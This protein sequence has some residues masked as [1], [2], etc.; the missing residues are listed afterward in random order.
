M[1]HSIWTRLALGAAGLLAL[2]GCFV[3]TQPGYYSQQPNTVYV[4][5]Q[6]RVV[7]TR[8]VY[9]NR[10]VYVTRPVAQPVRTVVVY[11]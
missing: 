11:R 1:T 4:Q 7:Y 10:P 3:R 2:G 9:V 8:P 6:P 5:Q